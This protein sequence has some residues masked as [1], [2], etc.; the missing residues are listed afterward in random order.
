MKSK[1]LIIFLSGLFLFG[2]DYEFREK[3]QVN[4]NANTAQGNQTAN[5][6]TYTGG[7]SDKTAGNSNSAELDPNTPLILAGTSEIRTIPCGGR[8]VEVVEDSTANSYTLTGECKKLTVDG[9]S[10]KINVEK[11]GEISVKG[12]SNEVTY[13]EGIDGNKPKITK[14]G[15]STEVFSLKELEKKK[16]AES[17]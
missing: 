16:A 6:Q 2:C 8:E 10:N 1:F 5:N 7:N 15:V 13:S 12:T 17:K 4:E 3:P 11:V 14:T 9:V